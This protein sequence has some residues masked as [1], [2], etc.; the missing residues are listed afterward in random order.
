MKKEKKKK[1]GNTKGRV[2]EIPDDFNIKLKMRELEL[3]SQGTITSVPQ[4]LIKYAMIGYLKETINT[5]TL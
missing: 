3:R 4:L 1:E 2:V 5:E